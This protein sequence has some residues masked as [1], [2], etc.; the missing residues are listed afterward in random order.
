MKIEKRLLAILLVALGFSANAQSS[1]ENEMRKNSIYFDMG[2]IPGFHAFV[3]YERSFYQ[4]KKVSWYGRM[5]AGY[6][7]F[8]FAAGGF[9]ALGAVTMLTGKKNSH[10][11]LNTGLF[12]GQEDGDSFTLPLI[13]VGYRYQKP[14]GGF[15][16]KAKIG[17]LGVGF[18]VG[19]A[20]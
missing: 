9:G 4:G 19:Y 7:G 12:S 2:F 3:N 8:L 14:E 11:E 6:G 18:G 13:D 17:I 1:E 16:F 15:V 5:G 20:F 10:F